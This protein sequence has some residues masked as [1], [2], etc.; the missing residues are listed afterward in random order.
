MGGIGKSTVALKVAQLGQERGWR[1]WWVNASDRISLK[2]G[3]LEVLEQ[4]NAPKSVVHAVREETPVAID[5]TWEFFSKVKAKRSLLI[6]DN[7][8]LPETLA[9]GTH[10]PADGTGWVRAKGPVLVIVT[11]RHGDPE[12]WGTAI[13]LRVL[14]PLDEVV[15]AA[16]LRDL[17]VGADIPD[18]GALD[19]ARRLGGLPLALHLAGTHLG[20]S[21]TRWH[22][23]GD[24]LSALGS[25]D[26]SDAVA[27]LDNPRADARL[28][29]AGTWELSVDALA[30]R[31]LPQARAL[32]CLLSCF[33]P[34]TPIPVHFLKPA[35]LG[36]LITPYRGAEAESRSGS[37]GNQNRLILQG[38]RG[39]STVGLIDIG[40]RFRRDEDLV[41]TVHPVIADTNR[42]RLLAGNSQQ[43]LEIGCAAVQL[44]KAAAQPLDELNPEHWSRWQILI[45]HLRALLSWLA[46]QLGTQQFG[47]LLSVSNSAVGGL[48]WSG[49]WNE[50][51]DLARMSTAAAARMDADSEIV[52]GCR[53]ALAAAVAQQGRYAE[54]E[55]AFNQVLADRERIRNWSGPFNRD[56]ILPVLG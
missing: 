8:D 50:A 20:S 17:A 11:T 56:I 16:V 55:A 37:P 18:D 12:T 29:V 21:F 53:Q 22:S 30:D 25:T 28:T 27:D 2:G 35:L 48:I 5:R 19:L 44:V 7:A 49:D 14:G 43:L 47:T 13:Q 39:L 54:A 9:S 26:F 31:G 6:L 42:V 32:L 52:L 24:Y 23:F 3:M 45:P 51:E 33:A 10:T 34:S 36:D 15:G 40:K 4:M 1:V 38:L 46:P 41:V